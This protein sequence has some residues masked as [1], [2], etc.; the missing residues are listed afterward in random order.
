VWL[1]SPVLQ[2]RQW[3]LLEPIAK[4]VDCRWA[5]LPC[6]LVQ[7][8]VAVRRCFG[9]LTNGLPLVWCG[10]CRRRNC[11]CWRTPLV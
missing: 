7:A 8:W 1:Y 10:V 3:G 4:G 6:D 11:A 5:V 9:C 2:A